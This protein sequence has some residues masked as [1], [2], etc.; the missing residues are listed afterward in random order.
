MVLNN[1][2]SAYAHT[3]S[4]TRTYTN[5][6]QTPHR[7]G[8]VPLW[9]CSIWSFSTVVMFTQHAP[10]SVSFVDGACVWCSS[11]KTSVRCR[12]SGSVYTHGYTTDFPARLWECARLSACVHVC[13]SGYISCNR[14]TCWP[15]FTWSSCWFQCAPLPLPSASEQCK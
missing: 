3:H 1:N 9:W 12:Q 7:S 6:M 15:L 14:Y 13:G 8:H 11:W 4:C 5:Y 2:E 10:K